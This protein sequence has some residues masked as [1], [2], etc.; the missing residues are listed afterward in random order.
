MRII[1]TMDFD[2]IIFPGLFY[3][4]RYIQKQICQGFLVMTAE[5]AI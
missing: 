3:G 4:E 1:K 5:I 2:L